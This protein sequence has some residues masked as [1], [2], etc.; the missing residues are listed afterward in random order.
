MCSVYY[1]MSQK[2]SNLP[3]KHRNNVNI[4]KTKLQKCRNLKINLA[5]PEDRCPVVHL[6]REGHEPRWLPKLR[7]VNMGHPLSFPAFLPIIAVSFPQKSLHYQE[8]SACEVP[9]ISYTV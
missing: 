3:K 2:H 4:N 7:H 6:Q 9:F 1:Q 5:I 8:L